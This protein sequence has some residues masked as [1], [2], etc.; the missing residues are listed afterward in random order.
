MRL[1]GYNVFCIRYHVPLY[2][3]SI[4][5]KLKYWNFFAILCLELPKVLLFPLYVFD[6]IWFPPPPPPPP[7]PPS[8]IKNPTSQSWKLSSN[9]FW[10]KPNSVLTKKLF[11]LKLLCN[12]LSYLHQ[13]FEKDIREFKILKFGDCYQF[14]LFRQLQT[15]FM[16][17]CQEIKQNLTGRKKFW[18]LFLHHFWPLVQKFYLWR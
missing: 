13:S 2:L 16:K 12:A 14:C 8:Y 7:P 4:Q 9:A 18:Y 6:M 10:P 3:W 17:Q 1:L 11:N 15:K 5:P